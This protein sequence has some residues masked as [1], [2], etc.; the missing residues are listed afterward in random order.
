MQYKTLGNTGLKVSVLG[1][2]ASPLGNEFRQTTEEEGKRAVDLA[3][4]RGINYFDTSPFYGRTLSEERLGK[5]LEGQ[6]DKVIVATKC[7]RYDSHTF[8]FSRERT[9]LSI[10]ESLR[11]LRTDHVDVLQAHDIEF[12]DMNQ[13]IDETI[14]AMLKIKESGKAR[15]IGV[16]SLQLKVMVR[17]AQAHPIDT[18][19]TYC[20]YNL[21]ITDMDELL[22]PAAKE[23][24]LGLINASPLHMRILTEAGAP[25]WHPAPESVKRAGGKV[26]AICREAGADP[27]DVALR[28]CIGHPDV[29]TTLVGM[30]RPDHVE[31]NIRGIETPVDPELLRKIAEAVEPVKN[32]SWASGRLENCDYDYAEA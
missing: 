20:R 21:M 31:N 2:G 5:F 29:A 1:F 26:V 8:D 11:R 10:D 14:P 24:G 32:T 18:V 27:A 12:R 23:K 3:I 28:F 13:V 30:S 19:L 9:M 22:T 15:F 17:A 25:D 7:G 6:R 4:D 16:T